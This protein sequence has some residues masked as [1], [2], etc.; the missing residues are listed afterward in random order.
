[1]SSKLE[2]LFTKL[3]HMF[4]RLS[5]LGPLLARV[6]I[7]VVFI[8]SGWGK[9]HNLSKVIDYFQSLGIPAAQYQAPF[10]AGTE[11]FAGL[12]VLIGLATRFASVPLSAIMLVAIATAKSSEIGTWTD[13]F[14]FTEVLYLVLLV[15]LI[16]H[17]AGAL[18]CDAVIA[19]N[20]AR[21]H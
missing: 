21:K 9:L 8:E 14:G 13:I 7:G 2:I 20:R 17:G 1:M 16:V 11:F 15:W 12:L 10:V 18:S 3:I 19:K 6:T 4:N 5:W